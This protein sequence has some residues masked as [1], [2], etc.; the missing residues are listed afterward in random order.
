MGQVVL[1][2]QKGPAVSKMQKKKKK[3]KQGEVGDIQLVR[4]PQFQNSTLKSACLQRREG[5][6]IRIGVTPH[7]MDEKPSFRKRASS[8]RCTGQWGPRSHQGSA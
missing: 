4:G 8:P 6:P 1:E 5:G 7:F 3:S 2:L